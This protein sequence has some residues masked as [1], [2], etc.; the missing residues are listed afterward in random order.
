MDSQ[1]QFKTVTVCR[2]S[3]MAALGRP[4]GAYADFEAGLKRVMEEDEH[5]QP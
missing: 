2:R 3:P 5:S 4:W 1:K